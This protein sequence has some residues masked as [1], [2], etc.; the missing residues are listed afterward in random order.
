MGKSTR[1][2][3]RSILAMIHFWIFGIA[4]TTFGI[5]FFIT[6]KQTVSDYEKRKLSPFPTFSWNS[7]FH[8]G[9][10]DSIDLYVADNFPYRD[11]LVEFSFGTK[12]WRGIKN[13]EIAF[14]D[15]ADIKKAD[16]VN[17]KPADS[18]S[19][20]AA[21][22]TTAGPP[23]EEVNNLFIVEGRA[24]EI[25][26]GNCNMAQSYARTI[27]KYQTELKGKV[28]IYD[29]AVPSAIEYFAPP[30]YAKQYSNQKKNIDCVYGAL[31]PAIK[32]VDAHSSIGAHKN[33]NIY[34]R[35][36]HHWTGLGA[37]YAYTAYCASAGLTPLQLNQME[38]KQKTGYL[39]SLYWLTRDA[40]LKETPDTVDY[41]KIPGKYKTTAQ[42]KGSDKFYASSIYAEGAS[43]ANG[44]GVFLGGD[45]PLVKIESEVKNGKKAILVKNSY[46][47]PF[48]T[49]LPYHYETV[50]VIDYRYYTGSIAKLI[51]D[52]KVTDLIFL[53]G[54]FSINTSW[55]IMMIGKNLHGVGKKAP[56]P[57]PEDTTKP[58]KDSI[59][60]KKEDS[61]PKED[62]PK[63]E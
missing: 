14:Y 44:Y 49:Y 39:G 55:H 48:A 47:N 26:G 40:R 28:Q 8:G 25:F 32:G 35:T 20:T 6:P 31:D 5:I 30:Q 3:T 56:V 52:E 10:I 18:V 62:G 59:I 11:Q 38:H 34:F 19:D 24:M 53:N 27:N 2:K 50:Y 58:K 54:V 13:D 15:A 17:V 1:S 37:Y 7:F 60:G 61:V 63:D 29:I 9:Y 43:G 21:T 16:P 12:A 57:T 36:D 4:L 46:G 45:Y 42:H 51:E 41:W 23:G 33:E 22:D